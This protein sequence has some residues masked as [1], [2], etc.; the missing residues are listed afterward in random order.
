MYYNWST[1]HWVLDE[2]WYSQHTSYG[3]FSR[4]ANPYPTQLSYPGRVGGYPMDPDLCWRG[5][6]RSVQRPPSGKG[7]LMNPTVREFGAGRKAWLRQ[8]VTCVFLLASMHFRPADAQRLLPEYPSNQ[9]ELSRSPCLVSCLYDHQHRLFPVD[10]IARSDH[11]REG[12]AAGAILGALGGAWLAN[13]FCED[14]QPCFGRTV[15]GGLVGAAT[16]F[17]VGALL[18]SLFPKP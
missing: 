10:S 11:W 18:G 5:R 1:L 2:A 15:A 8:G 12:A 14:G 13:G 6:G 4:G 17:G 9:V 7:L 16:G 3:V